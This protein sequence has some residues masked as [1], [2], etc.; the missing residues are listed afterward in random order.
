MSKRIIITDSASDIS[1]EN[2][3]ALNI[4]VLP[5][6]VAV[7]DKTLTSR[8]DFSNEEF[9][10]ILENAKKLPTTSQITP[11]DF[12]ELYLQLF[13]EGYEDVILVLINSEGSATFNNSKN[14]AKTF[15][16]EHP[17]AEGKINFYSVDGRSY[18]CAYGHPVTVAA[19]KLIDGVSTKKIVE[20]LEDYMQ[21]SIIYAGL[22]TLKYA[23]KSGRIPS[24]AAFVGDALG[25]KPLMRI[26]D[27]HITTK[28]KVRGEKK[29]IPAILEKI[30]EVM[31]PKS[32][33]CVVCGNDKELGQKMAD[34]ATEKFGYAPVEI[35][36]I[37]AA[38]AINAG[39]KV[40][41]ISCLRKK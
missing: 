31:E 5:F 17:E 38:I 34:A 39:P 24:A 8:V 32:E 37:G 30:E 6:Q 29:I 23:A 36:R 27:N 10:T 41:G 26:C 20:Y 22:Y 35:Y 19:K 40:V 16:E 18:S 3:K 13:Q 25:L 21:R 2:E 7:D 33:Y 14:A 11:Y 1:V 9:Y 12:G 15:F 4:K 28:D